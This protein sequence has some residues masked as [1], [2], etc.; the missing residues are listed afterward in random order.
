M[1]RRAISRRPPP[2]ALGPALAGAVLDRDSGSGLAGDALLAPG[3]EGYNVG[4][5]SGASLAPPPLRSPDSPTC[6]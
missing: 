3:R 5:F 6:P 4:R 2:A 1:R